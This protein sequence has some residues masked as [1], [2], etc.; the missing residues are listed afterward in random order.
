MWRLLQNQ[1]ACAMLNECCRVLYCSEETDRCDGAQYRNFP[2][3]IRKAEREK[4]SSF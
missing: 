1:R 2:Y 3:S 4:E